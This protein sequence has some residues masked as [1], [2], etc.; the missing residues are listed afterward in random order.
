MPLRGLNFI[1][2]ALTL[3]ALARRV[4]ARK[5]KKEAEG[6]TDEKKKGQNKHSKQKAHNIETDTQKTSETKK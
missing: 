5:P 4:I 1:R 2:V 3:E 6:K